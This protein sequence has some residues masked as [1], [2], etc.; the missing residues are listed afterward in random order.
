MRIIARRRADDRPGLSHRC[1]PP[2]LAI[3][4]CPDQM[5]VRIRAGLVHL[6]HTQILGAVNPIAMQSRDLDIIESIDVVVGGIAI[7]EG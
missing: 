5:Q 7:Q 4:L 6:R 2:G 3:D 1:D